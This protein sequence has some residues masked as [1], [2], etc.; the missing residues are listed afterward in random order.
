MNNLTPLRKEE[1]P[2]IGLME[3]SEKPGA[4]GPA[5]PPSA[6]DAKLRHS[7]NA[8]QRSHRGSYICPGGSPATQSCAAAEQLPRRGESGPAARAASGAGHGGR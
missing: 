2:L 4:G 1:N 8:K 7:P 6:L 5:Q 3:H